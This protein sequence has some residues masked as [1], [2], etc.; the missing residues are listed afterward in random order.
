MSSN[1]LK[2]VRC[3]EHSGAISDETRSH[4]EKLAEKKS[5]HCKMVRRI[6][7]MQGKPVTSNRATDKT[8]VFLYLRS[9]SR[10]WTVNCRS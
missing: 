10:Q 8:V 7:G 6:L 2:L 1:V 9:H 5:H 4:F 3:H